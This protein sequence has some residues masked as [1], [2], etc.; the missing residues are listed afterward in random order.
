[1]VCQ[2]MIMGWPGSYWV[3]VCHVI[4][5]STGVT[6]ALTTQ[7]GGTVLHEVLAGRQVYV[8]RSYKDVQIFHFSV[9]PHVSVAHFNFTANDTLACDAR[10]IT[11]FLQAQSYPVV[12]PD[13]AEFP[14]GMWINR[15]HVYEVHLR[16]DLK[17]ALLSVPFPVAGDWFMVAFINDTSNRITQAGLFPSCHSWLQ[18]EVEYRQE[19]QIT[20]VVPEIHSHQEIQLY[21]K[22]EGSEYYRFYVPSSTWLVVVNISKC[23]VLDEGEGSPSC[24]IDVG[25]RT[26]ALPDPNSTDTVVHNC[27]DDG[28]VCTVEVVPEEEAWHY[29][30]LSTHQAAVQLSMAVKF[31][32][33]DEP[34]GSSYHLLSRLYLNQ[35]CSEGSSIQN[36]P[37]MSNDTANEVNSTTESEENAD[38]M[39]SRRI[40]FMPSVKRKRNLQ[41]SCWPRHNLVKKTFGGNFVFEFDLPPDENGSVPL[42]LNITND[43]PTLLTFNLE[44]IIDIGGTLSVE[45]AV[46][47]FMNITLHNFTVDACVSHGKRKEPNL[48][49]DAEFKCPRGHGLHVNTSS[50]SAAATSVLIPFP[51]PGPWYLTLRSG[52]YLSNASEVTECT[53][54]ETTVL[55]SITS[56]S[57]LHGKCGRYGSCYQYISGG[58]IFSTCVCDAGYRGWACTDKSQAMANWQ[59]IL[60][61]LLLTL[62]NL[63][64]LPAIILALKRRYFA[65]A[66]VYAFTMVFSTFYHACDQ[67]PYNFCLMRLSVMQ[68]CDFYS[69][70]L[71][72]WVTLIA[73]ADLPHSLYSFLHVAG[74]LVVALG[75]EY[76][77]TGLWVFVVPSASAFL[78]MVASWVWHCKH[79]HSCYPTKWYW[80]TCLLPGVL[81]SAT[82][83]FCYAFLETHDNYYYVHSVWHAT[84]ALAILC[85]LPPRREKDER[86]DGEEVEPLPVCEAQPHFIEAQV[87]SPVP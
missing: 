52:C 6:L 18:S 40:L 33:C 77:R 20:T 65:E 15:S 71:S 21:Q 69:A 81:L 80:L 12:N 23:V 67:Q 53:V 42:L 75:V 57:C 14:P 5:L 68:F 43:S 73:M 61:T 26:R 66:V 39:E 34:G 9:P 56:A 58:F 55:F 35:L 27:A 4:L 62:S 24:P 29:I 83:L 36:L 16:S 70:I 78:I 44:P 49:V 46:S 25:F 7:E 60:A 30:Q 22:V 63:F 11:A 19:D 59:L 10:N 84:M 37:L 3:S 41:D 85:L 38:N 17:P 76:D 8:Y 51:E 48:D 13:G 28:E 82:G 79:L 45:L 50:L 86:G 72:F 64:F 54:N 74:A 87:Y 47:P 1:M 2:R 31:Y 32:M